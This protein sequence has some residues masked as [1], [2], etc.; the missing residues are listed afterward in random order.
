M[1]DLFDSYED[2]DPDAEFDD[3]AYLP[4]PDDEFAY[5]PRLDWDR[6]GTRSD[7]DEYD[8]DNPISVATY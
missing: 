8:R 1:D 3:A 2:Y 7:Y 4:D 5:D 6:V